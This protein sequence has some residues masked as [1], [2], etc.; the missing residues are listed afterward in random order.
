MTLQHLLDQLFGKEYLSRFCT[1][2]Q[3]NLDALD[4]PV[5][6]EWL[7]TCGYVTL[8]PLSVPQYERGKVE[9][10]VKERLLT[11]LLEQTQISLT[12]RTAAA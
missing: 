2:V 8:L 7:L 5:T 12:T 11:D 3:A 1:T 10:T 6:M 4:V 9:R